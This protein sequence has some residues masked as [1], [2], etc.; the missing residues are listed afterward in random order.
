MLQPIAIGESNFARIRGSGC[1]Y[2]DKTGFVAEVLR[3][4]SAVVLYCRPRRFGKTLNL[5]T[6]KAFVERSD[7]DLR[8]LFRGLAIER[9]GED[10]WRHFQRS[11]VIWLSF[12]DAKG[13]TWADA[14]AGIAAEI[15]LMAFELAATIRPVLDRLEVP[16]YERMCDGTAIQP[17]HRTA[18]RRL[19]LW[20][21]RA[22]GERTFILIDEY[23]SPIHSAQQYGYL[24]EALAF[25]R[26]FFGSGLKDNEHLGRAVLTGILR[27]AKESL[28]SDL[29]NLTVNTMLSKSYGQYFGFTEQEV[30]E[31]AAA[32]DLS[33][34]VQ[35]EMRAFY[36]GYRIGGFDIYNPWSVT[37]FLRDGGS[38]LVPYWVNTGENS[39]VR[40]LL[41]DRGTV[42]SAELEA[43]L[44]GD[45]ITVTVDDQVAMQHV[46][47]QD[48][49]LYAYLLFAG[50]LR[51]E[52]SSYEEHGLQVTVCVP[53]TEVRQELRQLVRTP[54]DHGSLGLASRIAAC[55]LEGDA[56]AF[57]AHLQAALLR[58]LSFHD[59]GGRTPERVYQAF[60]AGLLV[61]LDATHRVETN[62]ESGHGRADVLIIPRRAG[63][64][65]VVMELKVGSHRQLSAALKQL[66]RRDYAA[67]LR[68]A[69][70]STIRLLAAAF[71]GKRVKVRFA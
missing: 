11:P 33:P 19:S 36:N 44:R 52:S 1:L 3:E 34:A 37:N 4:S 57:E 56:A 28:F 27:V 16:I 23:D 59:L 67:T 42:E 64:V 14:A 30:S 51:V 49:T 21:W 39:A 47:N 38:D 40:D 8:P 46:S 54:L 32:A 43:L 45:A 25:F 12:K 60:V 5:R 35:Q 41:V 20:L 17:D 31:L 63:D 9:E 15:A 53:N 18:L 71:D 13:R 26:T 65:G 50:Y 7:E 69:G 29:N 10:V 2:V 24:P 6:L 58:V 68:D 22:T 70:A 55:L 48:N 61:I 66:A 62:R